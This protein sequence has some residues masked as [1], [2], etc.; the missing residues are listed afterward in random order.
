MTTVNFKWHGVIG[1]V[2]ILLFGLLMAIR[3]D[4]FERAQ[5]VP[6]PAATLAEGSRSED[7][8]MAI[9]QEGRKIGYAHRTLNRTDRGWRLEESVLMRIN[10]MGVVQDMRL[11]TTGDLLPDMTLSSFRFEL[12]SSLFRFVARGE[13]RGRQATIY[14]GLPAAPYSTRRSSRSWGSRKR[15]AR[16]RWILWAR[17]SLPG[18][19][20]TAPS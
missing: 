15:P 19:A 20:K 12:Q 8:W 5:S 17:N 11:K 3:L 18:S 14:Y 7:E 16:S 6:G 9:S 4:V 2:V 1:G 13:V 10:T